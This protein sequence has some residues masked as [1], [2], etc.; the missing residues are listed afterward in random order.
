MPLARP[1]S[2]VDKIKFLQERWSKELYL[3]AITKRARVRNIFFSTD[4]KDHA[5]HSQK[6]TDNLGNLSSI[7]KYDFHLQILHARVSEYSD[8]TINGK[9]PYR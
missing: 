2:S 3:S 5:N 8:S 1:E 7:D 4:Q 6:M 9:S